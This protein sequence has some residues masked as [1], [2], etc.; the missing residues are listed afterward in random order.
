MKLLVD[1]DNKFSE[2]S[3]IYS[4]FTRNMDSF[5]FPVLP[6]NTHLSCRKVRPKSIKENSLL[7]RMKTQLLWSSGIFMAG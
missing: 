5:L 2:G 1:M 3:P 7:S 4:N 6:V